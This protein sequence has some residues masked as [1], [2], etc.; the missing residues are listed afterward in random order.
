MD[1]IVIIFLVG[2]VVNPRLV[3]LHALSRMSTVGHT[4]ATVPLPVQRTRQSQISAIKL[5]MSQSM[6][7]NQCKIEFINHYFLLHKRLKTATRPAKPAAAKKTYL[8][9]VSNRF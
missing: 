8:Q 2:L 9:F 1:R 7:A 3:H 4:R 6:V 5:L